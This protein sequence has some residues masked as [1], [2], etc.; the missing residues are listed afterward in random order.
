MPVRDLHNKAWRRFLTNLSFILFGLSGLLGV[1]VSASYIL[2]GPCR[3]RQPQF[4]TAP[5]PQAAHPSLPQAAHPALQNGT[6]NGADVSGAVRPPPGG[7]VRSAANGTGVSASAAGSTGAGLE[8][9]SGGGGGGTAVAHS[10]A[11]H[12]AD[13]HAGASGQWPTFEVRAPSVMLPRLSKTSFHVWG[14]VWLRRALPVV[15][16]LW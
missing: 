16:M 10:S 8:S 11:V 1:A 12:S 14:Q 7:G 3:L 15:G 9:G 6:A 4:L 13:V 2:R 5:A